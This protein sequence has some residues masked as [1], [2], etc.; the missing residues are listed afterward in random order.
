MTAFSPMEVN[1]PTATPLPSRALGAIDA[2]GEMPD[3]TGR[4]AKYLATT[5]AT[6]K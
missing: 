3:G 4:A 2:C 6:A 1:A 5:R